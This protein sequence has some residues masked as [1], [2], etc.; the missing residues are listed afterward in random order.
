MTPELAHIRADYQVILDFINPNSRVLDL[1]CGNGELLDLLRTHKQS[2]GYGVEISQAGVMECIAQGISVF[3]GDIDQGLADY[4]PKSF[5]YVILNQTLQMV[6]KPSFVIKEMLRVGHKVILA[7][8]N[9][10]YWEIRWHMLVNG[11]MPKT[12]AVPFE[13]YD[14]PN[15]HML[16]IKDFRIY[17]RSLNYKIC[18]EHHLCDLGEN[19][20]RPVNK[21]ANLLAAYGMFEISAS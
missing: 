10:G 18:K 13:W 17:C 2:T 11:R 4:D 12:T 3:Q 14:T 15:I 7:F 19:D 9:F 21:R 5:D 1:G 8:P 6:H 16:T 20:V